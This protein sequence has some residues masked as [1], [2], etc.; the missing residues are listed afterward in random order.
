[1]NKILDIPQI[2]NASPGKRLKLAEDLLDSIGDLDITKEF[3]SELLRRGD[4][5]ALNP[6]SGRSWPKVRASRR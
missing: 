4:E 3:K 2:K 6:K 5:L 1:M